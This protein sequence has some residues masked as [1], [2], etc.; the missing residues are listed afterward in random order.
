MISIGLR[1]NPSLALTKFLDSKDVPKPEEESANDDESV[2]SYMLFSEPLVESGE[3]GSSDEPWEEIQHFG[4]DEADPESQA[5]ALGM[6]EPVEGNVVASSG[7]S[8]DE[9]HEPAFHQTTTQSITEP[10]HAETAD[11]AE[12]SMESS[13]RDTPGITSPPRP[14]NTQS[15]GLNPPTT[16]GH[17]RS[18]TSSGQSAGSSTSSRSSRL[19]T[20]VHQNPV[21]DYDTG[22][23]DGEDVALGREGER[24]VIEWER[25][26]GRIATSMNEDRENHE[27]Y[28]IE[29]EGSQEKR[30]IE[31]KSIRHNWTQLGVGVTKAQ[32]EA[33]ERFGRSWW[34]Y[35]VEYAGDSSKAVIHEIPNPFMQASEYRFDDGWRD[36]ADGSE[37]N[38]GAKEPVVDETYERGDGSPV[39]I[40]SGKKMGGLWRVEIE[41]SDGQTMNVAWSPTW[42]K[43]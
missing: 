2:K 42:R 1:L 38:T 15:G 36:L 16:P 41:C 26:Q 21:S 35:V 11:R 9:N 14:P 39:T 19:R 28:D 33:A 23:S 24:L 3:E 27:G 43:V 34:L 29:S 32:K 40:K 13:Q 6:E 31:V 4:H 12:H 20:Y 10:I 17:G 8:C 18:S 37:E 22:E 5:G 30:C 25:Q 7:D